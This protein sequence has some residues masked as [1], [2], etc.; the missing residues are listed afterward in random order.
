[1]TDK[2]LRAGIKEEATGKARDVHSGQIDLEDL[3]RERGPALAKAQPSEEAAQ[4]TNQSRTTCSADEATSRATLRKTYKVHPAA[5]VFPMMSDAELD[6]LA[7]DIKANGLKHPIMIQRDSNPQVLLDGR[8]RLEAM[9]RAGINTHVD[10][11][12]YGGDPIAHIIGL[13]IRRR[14]LTKKQRSDLIVKATSA[15]KE[16]SE[17]EDVSRQVGGKLSKRG[18]AEGRKFN[19]LKAKAVAIAKEHGIGERTVERSLAKVQGPLIHRPKWALTAEERLDAKRTAYL[20]ECEKQ[21]V[22]LDAEQEIII[23]AFRDIAGKKAK[24]AA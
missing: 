3:L 12:D 14:H 23:T 20:R 7:E 6:V 15:A 10:E 21:S 24:E 13:N 22:D 5:D 4:L 17:V 11:Q 2:N 18:R 9:E 19:P 16:K 1:M 8:N